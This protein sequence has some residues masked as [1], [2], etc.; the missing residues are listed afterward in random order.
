[1]KGCDVCNAG[2]MVM[3]VLEMKMVDLDIGTE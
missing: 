3:F 2:V 1:M